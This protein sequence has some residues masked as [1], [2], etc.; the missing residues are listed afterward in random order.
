ML[1]KREG[2]SPC[3]H[4]F[5]LKLHLEDVRLAVLL[6]FSSLTLACS[7]LSRHGCHPLPH[8]S[9]SMQLREVAFNV[10]AFLLARPSSLL[11]EDFLLSGLISLNDARVCVIIYY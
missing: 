9:G 2:Y 4:S 3:G 5:L 11:L 10:S 7:A 6:Y 8:P 1:G